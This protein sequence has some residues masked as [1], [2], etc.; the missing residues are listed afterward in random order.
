MQ[1]V[2][3][4]KK[5]SIYIVLLL[6]LLFFLVPFLILLFNAFK[7]NAEII[8]SPFS[9]PVSISFKNFGLAMDQMK[10]WSAFSN[11]A[12]ITFISLTVILICSA[13]TAHYFVRNK[14]RMNTMWFLMM[15]ASM[16]I[17]FQSIMIPLV[18]IYGAELGWIQ[19]QPKLTLMFMYVGFGSSL[20]VFVYH[21][22]I[23]SIPLELEEAAQ[24]D[25]CNSIQTFFKIV[26][27]ILMP[28]A[29]TI[30]ILHVLWIWNDY[31]LP[32]LILQNAGSD[33]Y[34]LPLA[35]QVFRGSYS[36]DYERYLPAVVMVVLPIMVVYLFAQRFIIQ[37][38]TQGSVK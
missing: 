12:M 33:N 9:L 11:S 29:V 22:F 30:G 34:T 37:G 19:S 20:A 35:I 2:N 24:I 10:Y 25:G 28:T 18:S 14:T 27:P 31:L 3:A 38:V 36:S 23:K 13:M 32:V 5:G 8:A 26:L 15:V 21:G 16:I 1:M 17:P 7:T 4:L 6:A